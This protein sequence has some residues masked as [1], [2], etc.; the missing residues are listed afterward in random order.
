MSF[1]DSPRE[2]VQERDLLTQPQWYA[3]HSRSR[4]EKRIAL[5]LEDKGIT[6]YLPIKKLQRK[7]KDRKKVIDFPLFPCYLFVHIPL[8]NKKT[9][10]QTKG[11]VRILGFPEPVPVPDNQ[12]EALKRF[13]TKDVEVDPYPEI[14]PGKEIEVKKGPFR[15]IRGYVIQKNKKYRLLVGLELISQVVSVEIDIEDVK[16]TEI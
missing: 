10:I 14:F 8:V 16:A 2:N 9:V 3:V 11:V 15:G 12:I 1:Q 4:F 5:L 6:C 13:E 7:W